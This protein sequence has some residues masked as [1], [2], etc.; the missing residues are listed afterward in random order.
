MLVQIF[1]SINTLILF[2]KSSLHIF[3]PD[4]GG[5]TIAGFQLNGKEEIV[6]L[7]FIYGIVQKLLFLQ[8]IV[9]LFYSNDENLMEMMI[10]M[11]TFIGIFASF[12]IKF[13][14][15]FKSHNLPKLPINNKLRPGR[16]Q[17]LVDIFVGIVY[18]VMKRLTC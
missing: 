18:I 8:Y 6:T 16:Y 7:L 1:L 10:Y 15:H 3:L 14:K 11:Q 12:Y 2:V 5:Y 9:V 4:S 17:Y 13:W